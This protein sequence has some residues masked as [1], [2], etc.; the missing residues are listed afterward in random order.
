MKLFLIGLLL[1]YSAFAVEMKDINQVV[2]GEFKLD[3]IN[4]EMNLTEINSQEKLPGKVKFIEALRLALKSYMN[5]ASDSE[6]PL[7]LV[8]DRV[9]REKKAKKQLFNLMNRKTTTLFVTK[10]D[11]TPEGD[12]E[13]S[14]N[15]IISLYLEDLSDHF[16]W[17]V[18]DRNGNEAVYNYGFN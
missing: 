5:D 7:A 11:E 17:A 9:N 1:S 16:H 13:V 10:I 3:K 8:S 6:S 2:V 4:L 18:T 12:E 14:E 15:W